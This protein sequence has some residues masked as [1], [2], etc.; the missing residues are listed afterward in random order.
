MAAILVMVQVLLSREP[1]RLLPDGGESLVGA[2]QP[3]GQMAVE[4]VLEMHRERP[5]LS[6]AAPG[7]RAKSAG[8]APL[9]R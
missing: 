1:D 9:V 8:P 4:A 2:G 5:L 6:H 7:R 3:I